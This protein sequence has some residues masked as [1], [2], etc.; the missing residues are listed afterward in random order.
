MLDACCV[1]LK[2]LGMMRT[3][4]QIRV[5]AVTRVLVSTVHGVLLSL[6]NV[7]LG[8]ASRHELPPVL[9]SDLER[10]EWVGFHAQ[11]WGHGRTTRGDAACTTTKTQGPLNTQCVA[12]TISTRTAHE[13]EH[14]VHQMVQVL[15]QQGFFCSAH[16]VALD[17]STLPTPKSDEG[18]GKHTHALCEDHRAERTRDGS[19]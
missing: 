4:E 16:L 17:G 8:A 5:S 13:R 18:Y 15:A 10:M 11:Q 12:D 14:L 19:I 7:L 6:L 3:Y 9:L 1:Y 2:V